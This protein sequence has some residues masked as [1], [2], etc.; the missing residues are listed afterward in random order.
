MPRADNTFR[1]VSTLRTLEL[2]ELNRILR[3]IQGDIASL[4]GQQGGIELRDAL[5]LLSPPKDPLVSNASATTL[6]HDITR[7]KLR[8]S[9]NALPY[10][11][12]VNAIGAW[13]SEQTALVGN[14]LSWDVQLSGEDN[15]FGWDGAATI[16]LK[17]SGVYLVAYRCFG[18]PNAGSLR[19]NLTV[20]TEG[21][22]ALFSGLG[23]N[24]TVTDFRPVVKVD[25]GAFLDITLDISAGTSIGSTGLLSSFLVALKVL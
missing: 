18:V 11:D 2:E 25:N 6:F 14:D 1:Q 9:E 15:T 19:V 12:V 21:N 22:R 8:A 13:S 4:R 7:E 23:G 3:K 10:G 17:Q 20:G 5:A 16:T 24:M